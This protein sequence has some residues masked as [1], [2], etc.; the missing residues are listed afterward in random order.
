MSELPI[1]ERRRARRH[2]LS[3]AACASDE[4]YAYAEILTALEAHGNNDLLPT[5]D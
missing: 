2:S 4:L 1:S 5:L 3:V